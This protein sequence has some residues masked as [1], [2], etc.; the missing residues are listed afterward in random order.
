MKQYVIIAS[1]NPHGREFLIYRMHAPSLET[2]ARQFRSQRGL[3]IVGAG[4]SVGDAPLG[5]SFMEGPAL[6]YAR[7]SGS[8]PTTIPVQSYLNRRILEAARSVLPSQ[9]FPGREYRYGTDDFPFLEIVQRMPNSHARL[10]LKH[11]LSMTRFAG[12]KSDNYRVFSQFRR[13]MV[14]NYNHDGL[15]ADFCSPFHDVI[16]MHGVVE[17]TYGSPAAAEWIAQVREYDLSLGPDDLL[18]CEPE[19]FQDI[20]LQRKF[21]RVARFQPDF[22]AIIGYSFGRNGERFD[23]QVSLDFFS[24]MLHGFAGNVYVIEPRPSAL[25]DMLTDRLASARVFGIPAF[26]NVLAHTIVRS[27]GGKNP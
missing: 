25:R 19:S 27:T 8:I 4:T 7:N 21:L 13:G 3:Y 12:R 24:R 1:S 6:D 11:T 2:I 18:M 20:A 15:A 14:V 9:V 5:Q 10:Y 17:R 23:D 22:V 16:N 26:W